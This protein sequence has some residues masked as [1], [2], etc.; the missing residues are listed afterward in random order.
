MYCIIVKTKL[1][2]GTEKAFLAAM[3]PNAEASVRE[4]EGCIVFDVLKDQ[5]DDDTFYLYEIYT[6]PDAL[7]VHKETKHYKDTRAIVN[8]LISEQSV[9][10]AG[11]T[12][13]NPEIK[14]R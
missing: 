14:S 1:H 10:R 3:M 13:L 6:S 8:A 2:P 4:E 7:A 5:D 9:V 11:V 12:A